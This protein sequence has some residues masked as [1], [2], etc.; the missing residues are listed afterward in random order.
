MNF[1][2]DFLLIGKHTS[3]CANFRSCSRGEGRLSCLKW[4]GWMEKKGNI[5]WE[6]SMLTGT[7]A[8]ACMNALN[9]CN[10]PMSW[11]QLPP[12]H[13]WRIQAQPYLLNLAWSG[14]VRSQTPNHYSL[15]SLHWSQGKNDPFTCLTVSD[16]W[17]GKKRKKLII[18]TC[19]YLITVW[20]EIMAMLL[21]LTFFIEWEKN[22]TRIV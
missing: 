12:C 2:V 13:G 9:A 3:L 6:S 21:Y 10:I 4:Y 15:D 22:P 1:Y 17:V 7:E 19:F 14:R 8:L 18:T 11:E 5:L 20:Y 16:L